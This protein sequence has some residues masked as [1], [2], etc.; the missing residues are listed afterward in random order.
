MV[1][2]KIIFI[3]VTRLWVPREIISEGQRVFDQKLWFEQDTTSEQ[4]RQGLYC[5]NNVISSLHQA[6]NSDNHEH[7]LCKKQDHHPQDLN[8]KKLI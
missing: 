7:L 4:K 8:K 3:G 2:I 6:A 1:P 5:D